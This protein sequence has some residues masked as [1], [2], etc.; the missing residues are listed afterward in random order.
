VSRLHSNYVFGTTDVALTT[1]AASYSDDFNRANG[2]L[3]STS[4]GGAAWSTPVGSVLIANQ[5]AVPQSSDSTAIINATTSDGTLEADFVAAGSGGCLAFRMAADGLTGYLWNATPGGQTLYKKTGAGAFTSIAN[6]GWYVA[7]GQRARVV[8][9]GSSIQLVNVT[10][11]NSLTVTDSSY[12]GTYMGIRADSTATAYDNFSFAGVAPSTGT[13]SSPGLARLPVVAAPDTAAVTLHNPATGVFEVVT[14]LAHASRATTATVLRAQEGTALQSWPSGTAWLHGITAADL[15][16]YAL[17]SAIPSLPYIVAAATLDPLK[18]SLNAGTSFVSGSPTS[19]ST[20]L[21]GTLSDY[22]GFTAG[23]GVRAGFT[24]SFG[25][26][27]TLDRIH[28]TM[29][30]AFS[31]TFRQ[32]QCEYTA[33]GS[34]W[35]ALGAAVDT[36][37]SIGGVDFVFSGIAAT[38]FRFWSTGRASDNSFYPAEVA[39]WTRQSVPLSDV[40]YVR[41]SGSSSGDD[42]FRAALSGYTAL[43]PS[44]SATWT[45]GGDSLGVAYTGQSANHLAA[46]VKPLP[47]GF[48][49][50]SRIQTA[51]RLLGYSGASNGT[52]LGGVILTNG[53]STTAAAVAACAWNSNVSSAQDVSFGAIYGSVSPSNTVNALNLVGSGGTVHLRLT[54]VAANT[55]RAEISPDG[56]AWSAFG[57]GDVSLALTPTHFGLCVSSWGNPTAGPQLTTFEYLRVA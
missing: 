47:A 41:P 29:Y 28:L 53:A 25:S 11:G 46:Q 16:Q 7:A 2:P 13:M 54:Y 19:Y 49:V 44:G 22:M 24:Y 12:A 56:N 31:E 5:T 55:W 21:N 15:A 57:L 17:S 52:A 42:E 26:T 37:A 6:V 40:I 39:V 36:Q 23:A 38:A 48:G 9:S 1:G 33:D 27:V 45:Q 34:T 10:T 51:F 8:L 18:F 20:L 50:G 3:G 30:Y 35:V 43:T 4:V 32:L 14:V